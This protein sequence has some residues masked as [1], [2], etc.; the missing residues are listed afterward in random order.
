M[1]LVVLVGLQ[2]SGKTAFFDAR[3]AATHA[4]VSKDL[5]PNARDRGA[6]QRSLVA[7]AAAAGRSVVVDNTNARREDRTALVAQAHA[8]G[9]RAVCC[10]F[11]PDV[12]AS[13][14][15][16]AARE[17]RARVPAVA[18]H[19]TRGR[20]VPPSWDEG[21]DELYEVR[22]EGGA[23]SIAPVPRSPSPAVPAP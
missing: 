18:I 12:R 14:A 13:L 19:A 9:M 3:Y 21:W 15:R 1:E 6:R 11:P 8:L 17:G 22:A 4:H 10:F 5:F 20:L 23:F 7:A 2:G 16:N